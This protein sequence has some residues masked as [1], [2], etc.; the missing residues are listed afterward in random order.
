M[1]VGQRIFHYHPSHV[2]VG[3]RVKYLS[4]HIVCRCLKSHFGGHQVAVGSIV[5]AYMCVNGSEC[6]VYELVVQQALD[7]SMLGYTIAEILN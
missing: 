6:E 1:K 7:Y 4:L 3:C 2:I 5:V